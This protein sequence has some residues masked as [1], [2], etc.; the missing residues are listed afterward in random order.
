LS[1]TILNASRIARYKQFLRRWRIGTLTALNNGWERVPHEAPT[2]GAASS[3]DRR[4]AGGYRR[5][6]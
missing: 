3:M 6:E 4:G 1:S 2:E 5:W